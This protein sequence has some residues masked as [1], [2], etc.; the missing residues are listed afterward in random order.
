MSKKFFK[1]FSL[2]LLPILMFSLTIA[3]AETKNQTSTEILKRGNYLVTAIMACG[4]CHT[5]VSSDFNPILNQELGGFKL[6]LVEVPFTAYAYNLTPAKESNVSKWTDAE[7]IRAIR[8]GKRP[9]GSIIGPAMPISMY[10]NISDEDVAAVVAYIRQVRP[11]HNQPLPKSEYKIPIPPQY[12]Q[13]ITKPIVAPSKKDQL[14]YG[15]YLAGPLGHCVECHTPMVKGRL[16]FAKIGAGGRVFKGP[17]GV[18]V[19]RNLTPDTT[20]LKNWSDAEIERAIRDGISKSGKLKEAPMPFSYFKKI[21]KEDMQAIIKYL[22]S[23]QPQP[24]GG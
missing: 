14:K 7:L 2:S 1:Y 13:P 8:E 6:G 17:W 11:V 10:H 20:G 24:F 5:P 23:L 18:A 19:A 16:D 4:N 9:D 15:E 21:S 22:R 12:G 3:E